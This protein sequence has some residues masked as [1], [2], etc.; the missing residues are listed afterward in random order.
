MPR[1]PL[2]DEERAERKR[3]AW[4]PNQFDQGK[5]GNPRQWQHAAKAH[6]GQIPADPEDPHLRILG[7]T[8]FPH[9]LRQLK[10]ARNA[11]MKR[12]HPDLA[13]GSTP[14]AQAVNE[15]YESLLNHLKRPQ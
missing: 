15:A 5:P 4:D 10:L 14:I 13:G 3:R 8:A 11:A 2:T 12:F 1:R 6:L 7:L 9:S